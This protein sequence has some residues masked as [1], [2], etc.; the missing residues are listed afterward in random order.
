[1]MTAIVSKTRE[2]GTATLGGL[3]TGAVLS[4]LLG[5]ANAPLYS[6]IGSFLGGI[7]AAYLL[8]GKLDQAVIVGALS[9]IL[10][11]PFLLGLSDIFAIFGLIPTPSG[12][13]PSLVELQ[14]VVVIIA[15][16]DLVAGAAGGAVLGAFHTPPRTIPLTPSPQS[17]PETTSAQ[18]RFCV[19]CGAPLPS[20]ALACPQCNARQPQ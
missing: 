8:R 3:I 20:G 6:A 7:V 5:L 11:T 13:T 2:L 17:A 18:G 10:G 19:Q 15:G 16:I 4:T 12:P 9:G 1:M 14:T